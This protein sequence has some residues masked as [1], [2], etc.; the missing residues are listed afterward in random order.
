M[1]PPVA[2]TAILADRAL[3]IWDHGYLLPLIV[4]CWVVSLIAVAVL[5]QMIVRPYRFE[6]RDRRRQVGR[7]RFRS[8]SYTKRTAAYLREQMS[9]DQIEVAA[10]AP[11][12]AGDRPEAFAPGDSAGR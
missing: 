12:E 1:V 9:Y 6:M 2:V 11:V 4:L 5:P 7:I 8:S 10:E 3:D